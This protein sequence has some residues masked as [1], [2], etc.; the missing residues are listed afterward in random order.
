MKRLLWSACVAFAACG[1]AP[2]AGDAGQHVDAGPQTPAFQ[3]ATLDAHNVERADAMP[4]PSPALTPMHWSADAGSLA[5]DW[6]ARCTFTH[7]DPNPLGENIYAGTAEPDIAEVIRYWASEK[8][9]FDYAANRCA[10]GKQCGH[11]TQIV[12]RSSVGVGCA[13]QRCATGS[14]FG[15]GA[16]SLVVCNYEPAGNYVGQKPY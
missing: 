2:G 10:T 9:D 6:A 4:A 12:W 3:Q 14:P 5:A 11:Y 16:W 7:R 13:V 8:A 15:G 1:E